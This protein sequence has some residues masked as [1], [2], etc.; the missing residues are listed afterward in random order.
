VVGYAGGAVTAD[1]S[2]LAVLANSAAKPREFHIVVLSLPRPEA[3][4][5]APARQERYRVNDWGGLD[6]AFAGDKLIVKSRNVKADTAVPAD[7]LAWHSAG[8]VTPLPGLN[9]AG[10]HLYAHKVV[11][12]F[13]RPGGFVVLGQN[14]LAFCT[15]SGAVAATAP[16]HPETW[17]PG[18]PGPSGIAAHPGG[19]LA[20]AGD[21]GL[22]VFDARDPHKAG[23]VATAA[24][25]KGWT[26]VRFCRPD[27]IVTFGI[28]L[29]EPSKPRDVL[30]WQM[31]GT[32][33]ERL[34]ARRLDAARDPVVIPGR[35]LIAVWE[36]GELRFLDSSTL[37]DAEPP[38]GV[39]RKANGL[40][41]SPGLD[42]CVLAGYEFVEVH[43]GLHAEAA[44][45]DRAPGTW[46]P[47]DLTLISGAL[48]GSTPGSSARPLLELLQAHLEHRFGT[49]VSIGSKA[50]AAAGADDVAL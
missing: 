50:R 24:L 28:R 35:D 11:P 43:D 12:W 45:A 1:G 42:R 9:T 31:D 14:R 19:M 16:L 47:R 41:N 46:A 34:A 27:R 8:T 38:E 40:W 30:L 39:A 44:I 49:D 13:A 33:L 37:A 7:R 20:V 22:A 26:S 23:P 32:R 48:Q 36:V 21:G 6:F 5:T 3:A 10:H 17:L 25:P 18:S 2:R 4:A 29:H 15:S